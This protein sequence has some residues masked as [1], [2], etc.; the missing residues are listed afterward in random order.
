[1]ISERNNKEWFNFIKILIVGFL[2]SVFMK[3]KKDEDE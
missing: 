2:A 3:E 1:M